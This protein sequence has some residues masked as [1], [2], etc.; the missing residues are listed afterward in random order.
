MT[1]QLVLDLPVRAA[2]G[3]SDFFVSPANAQALAA[4]DGWR[5]WPQ[6]KA[7]LTGPAGAGKSH[8]AQVWATTTG[9]CVLPAAELVQADLPALARGPVAIEDAGRI[10]GERAAETALFHLHNLLAESG[11]PLLVTAASPPRDWGL[12]LPDLASRM[13]A[14][15]LIRLDPPDDALLRA[16]LVKQFADRQVQV[17]PVV[18]DYLIPRMTRSLEAARKL[19]AEL[20]ARALAEGRPITRAMAAGWFEGPGLFDPD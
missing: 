15:L 4:L 11:Q 3:R 1:R 2:Q 18:I 5:A 20:D 7:V 9:A 13:Q 10:G 14:A 17:A 16:V 6:G 8:L 12:G 19:V